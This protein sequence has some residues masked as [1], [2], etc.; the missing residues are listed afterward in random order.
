[1]YIVLFDR[2]MDCENVGKF[3]YLGTTVKKS[4]L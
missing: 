4:K 2:G 3:K 1:M